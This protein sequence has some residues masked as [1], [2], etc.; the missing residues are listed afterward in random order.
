MRVFYT[1][2]AATGWTWTLFVAG[3]LVGRLTGRTESVQ[4]AEAPATHE[5]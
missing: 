3:F 2:L 5:E 1:I 4:P